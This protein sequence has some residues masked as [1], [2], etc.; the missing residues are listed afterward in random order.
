MFEKSK[1]IAYKYIDDKRKE[2]P[3]INKIINT[4]RKIYKQNND[5]K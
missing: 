3:Q 5:R 1:I 4:K 2:K